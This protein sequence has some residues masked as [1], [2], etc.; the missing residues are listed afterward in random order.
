M[1][2]RMSFA[3]DEQQQPIQDRVRCIVRDKVSRRRETQA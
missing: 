1:T 2:N 3:R